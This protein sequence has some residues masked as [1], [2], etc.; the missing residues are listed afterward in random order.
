MN[1][2]RHTSNKKKFFARK[3]TFIFASIYQE[4]KVSEYDVRD[5]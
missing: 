1:E 4:L 2:I 3:I 5:R